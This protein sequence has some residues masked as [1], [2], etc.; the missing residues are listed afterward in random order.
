MSQVDLDALTIERSAAPSRQPGA[1]RW[2]V[3][4]LTAV[5]LFVA[6]TFLVP[7]LRPAQEVRTGTIRLAGQAEGSARIGVAEAAGWIEPEPF[8]VYARPL[9]SGVLSE[10]LVLEGDAVKKG[11]TVLARLES[12]SLLARRDRAKADVELREAE[13]RRAEADAQVARSLLE[14]RGNA[15]LI[16]ARHK[17]DVVHEQAEARKAERDLAAAIAERE[18][19]QAEL[20]GQERLLEG[21]ASYPVALAKARAALRAADA[22]VERRRVDIE[23]IRDEIVQARIQLK[24]AEEL[25]DDPRGLA[26][27]LERMR[28]EVERK[29]AQLGASRVELRIAERELDWCELK[30]PMDGVVMK[31]LAAPGETV[32]PMGKSAVALYDPAHLQA[33][34]DVPLASI[35]GVHVGQQVEV[36]SEAVPG[37]VTKGVV[38]RVQRESDLLKN[39]TQVKV[40][41]L[42]PT[43]LL[44]P[45]TLCRARFLATK[46]EGGPEAVSELFRLPRSALKGGVVFVVDPTAGGRARRVAVEKVGDADLDVIVKGPLS[47][48]QRVILDDVT[49]GQRIREVAQ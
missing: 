32:G 38:L 20:E 17:Q 44:I 13:L 45:E 37:K 12:A 21:G 11:E 40:R 10:L 36:R 16:A 18:A 35:G 28:A 43:P 26:G 29:Q 47:V 2:G 4:G 5:V 15:R 19:K 49:D 1:R 9:V 41:L 23:R 8:A 46:R 22:I 7:L 33:R 27:E 31:L 25:K 42:D 24:I 30:A 39:T 3:I 6:G 34:I 14:Q 48:T